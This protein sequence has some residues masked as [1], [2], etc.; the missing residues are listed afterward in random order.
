MFPLMYINQE[1][2]N[3]TKHPNWTPKTCDQRTKHEQVRGFA[4]HVL[5]VEGAVEHLEVAAATVN[6]LLVLHCELHHQ[7]LVLVAEW[8]KL[9]RQAVEA[10][11]LEKS[12]SLFSWSGFLAFGYYCLVKV[13][14]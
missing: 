10:C 8:L 2:P 3:L 7:G 14:F 9:G 11:V 1:N 5:L 13:D 12:D 6:V 4:V